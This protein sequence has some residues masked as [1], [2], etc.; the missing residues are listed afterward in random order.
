MNTVGDDHDIVFRSASALGRER[1]RL[2]IVSTATPSR[3]ELS[4]SWAKALDSL[5]DETLGVGS[6]EG[7]YVAGIQITR[8]VV[9]GDVPLQRLDQA[10]TH[11]TSMKSCAL[12]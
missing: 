6:M 9:Y 10:P 12:V 5:A 8:E 7:R 1:T 2:S 4:S 3:R 11:Q